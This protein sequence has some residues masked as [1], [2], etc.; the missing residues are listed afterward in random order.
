MKKYIT[1]LLVL[2]LSLVLVA[3]D[4]NAERYESALNQIR[5]IYPNQ[6]QE[7]DVPPVVIV[8]GEDEEPVEPGT[9]TATWP[10]DVPE[11]K[12]YVKKYNYAADGDQF[13]ARFHMTDAQLETW[14][15]ELV[16]AGFK[17]LIYHNDVLVVDIETEPLDDYQVVTIH[18]YPCPKTPAWP[19]AFAAFPEFKGDGIITGFEITSDKGVQTLHITSKGESREAIGAYLKQLAAAGFVDYGEGCYS[20]IVGRTSYDFLNVDI[21]TE[22]T[23]DLYWHIYEI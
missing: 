5:G 14:K 2:C 11:V 23:A 12:D 6:K 10:K 15:R 20:R 17:G 18:I 3:C 7:E 16:A 1:I 21:W 19:E 4:T 22:T 9:P 8:D 13:R